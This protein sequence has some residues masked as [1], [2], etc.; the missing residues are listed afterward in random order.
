[1]FIIQIADLSHIFGGDIEQ[2]QTGVILKGKV[3]HYPQYSYDLIRI[4]L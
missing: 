2:N 4:H 3:P 1:M